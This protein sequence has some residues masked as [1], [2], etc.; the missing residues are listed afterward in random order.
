MARLPE[1]EIRF[2]QGGCPDCGAREVSLP[3]SLPDIEDDFDWRTR[4]YDS[5]RLFLM[6]ELAH[7]QP[8]RRRWTPADM[9]VVL[10]EVLAAALDRASHALDAVQAERFLET[11]RRPDSVRRLLSL[12]GYEAHE[13]TGPAV[14]EDGSPYL[15]GLDPGATV[16]ERVEWYWR[17]NPAA[18]ERARADGPRLIAEQRRMVT[19]EDHAIAL[20]DHPLVADARARTVS[21]N[22]WATLM[23]SV[24]PGEGVETQLGL[25]EEL[26]VGETGGNAIDEESYL[27]LADFHKRR[28][29]PPV[30]APTDLPTL[31]DLLRI[32]I[33]SWRMVGTEVLVEPA[34]SAPVTF[35][36]SVRAKRGYFRSELRQA[37]TRAFS[38]EPG[39]FFEIGRRG[40]GED[41]FASDL[42]EWAV[43]VEGVEV[44]CL[45]RF[46]RVGQ[47][48][49]DRTVA[50]FIEIGPHEYAEC[51][52]DRAQ[53]ERGR[54]SLQVN[55]GERG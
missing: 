53:P 28:G 55:G 32:L 45:N 38:S 40:F 22:G 9:E 21:M 8:E 3:L 35:A 7:R 50:G 36:L 24:I 26:R 16:A 31:R 25:D 39:G 20:R 19:L 42:I 44:A 47:G 30:A 51:R 12:I 17:S 43:A 15:A 29:L 49:R 18:M 37:L 52:S 1:P 11:A 46:K 13:H 5:F 54:F 23:V 48:Y 2:D 33:E 34:E 6:K 14:L 41:L 10:V 27:S 4:D